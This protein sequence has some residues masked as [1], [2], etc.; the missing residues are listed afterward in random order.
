VIVPLRDPIVRVPHACRRACAGETTGQRPDRHGSRPAVRHSN[1]SVI[2][3]TPLT[4]STNAQMRTELAQLRSGPHPARYSAAAAGAAGGRPALAPL[5]GKRPNGQSQPCTSGGAGIARGSTQ[6]PGPY[7]ACFSALSISWVR[8]RLDTAPIIRPVIRWLG[9][10]ISVL[11]KAVVGT[12][13]L[14][15]SAIL[16]AGS[17][18]LG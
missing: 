1:H 16:S 10:I 8:A 6:P 7:P 9:E 13:R 15:L 2:S 12:T 11:G 18:R 17:A 4:A 14:K 3:M 5:T